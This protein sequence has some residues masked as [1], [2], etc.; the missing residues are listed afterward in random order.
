MKYRKYQSTEIVVRNEKNPNKI[1]VVARCTTEEAK[2]FRNE[3]LTLTFRDEK[4]LEKY[5]S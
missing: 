3:N 2:N 1:R 4:S 5:L